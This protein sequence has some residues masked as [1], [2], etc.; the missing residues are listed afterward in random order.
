MLDGAEG[1]TWT[2]VSPEGEGTSK[3]MMM[4]PRLDTLNGKAVG[5]VWNGTFRGD[6]TFPMIA[7]MLRERYP[8]IRVVP[9]SE[10]PVPTSV[11]MEATRK[12]KML[13]SIKLALIERGCDAVIAGNGG[14]GNCTVSAARTAMVAESAGIPSATVAMTT[15]VPLVRQL[16]RAE[17]MPWL[18]TAQYPGTISVDSDET[19]R[20][21]LAVTVEQID[22]ALTGLADDSEEKDDDARSCTRSE[23]KFSF[24]GTAEDV[25]SFFLGKEWTD[26]LPIVPPTVSKVADFLKY[27]DFPP[28][29]VIAVLKPGNLA[30][31]PWII[32]ANAVMAGCEPKLMPIL[33]AAVKAIAHPDYNLEQIGTTAGHN[34]FL[35]VNGP[36]AKQLGIRSGVGLASFSPNVIIGRALGLMVRNIAGYKPAQQY[37]GT[38]GYI[39]P[40]VFAEDEEG[41]PWPSLRYDRG[42]D[43]ATSTVSAG[44]TFNWGF[45]A[46]PSGTDPEGILKIICREIVKNVNLD[47]S[48]HQGPL[49]GMTVVMTRGVAN[50]IADGG[51]SKSD[52]EDYLFNNSRATIEEVNFEVKYGNSSG[53]GTTLQALSMAGYNTPNEWL[54]LSPED[55]VPVMACPGLIRIV[56][57]GD[58]NRNKAMALYNCYSRMTT[59]RVD[60][61]KEW[62]DLLLE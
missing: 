30:A 59:K 56:V 25:N 39:M 35:V 16:A 52:A 58:P 14:C 36:I 31:T 32:A 47:T 26:G 48:S 23:R 60:L 5:M 9:F 22:R 3:P 55:T 7:E 34:P 62:N 29:D 37:M 33:V 42:F 50:A 57:C 8:E 49:Q 46:F 53:S 27:T 13:E 51:Y 43:D 45:Q 41:S 1:N 24:R 21:N 4:A 38:F 11:S 12:E 6:I 54:S 19:V 10:F 15:F 28:H 40:F 17:K 18:P 61:P 20:R 2:L 44:G